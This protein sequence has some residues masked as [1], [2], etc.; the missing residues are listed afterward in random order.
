M[1]IVKQFVEAFRLGNTI[2]GSN[3]FIWQTF[4]LP[5]TTKPR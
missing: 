3:V 1:Y 5:P 2:G 4:G